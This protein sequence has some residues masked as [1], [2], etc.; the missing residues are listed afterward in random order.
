MNDK[1]IEKLLKSTT[2]EEF[3][4]ILVNDL[5][6]NEEQE[7]NIDLWDKRV[8]EHCMKLTNLSYEELKKEMEID[9]LEYYN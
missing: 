2:E 1:L 9:E 6:L 5:S 4:K 7:E 8:V 3:F